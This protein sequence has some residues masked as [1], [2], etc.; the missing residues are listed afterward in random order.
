MSSYYSDSESEEEPAPKKPTVSGDVF[1]KDKLYLK[2]VKIMAFD[3]P[4]NLKLYNYHKS[5]TDLI[6]NVNAELNKLNNESDNL[7]DKYRKM[8]KLLVDN[9]SKFHKDHYYEYTKNAWVCIKLQ[10]PDEDIVPDAQMP[11]Y[12]KVEEE[13]TKIYLT[14]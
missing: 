10:I 7:L 5:V 14:T 8:A 1:D 12:R 11:K 6:A 13:I 4:A 2:S 3:V 9:R